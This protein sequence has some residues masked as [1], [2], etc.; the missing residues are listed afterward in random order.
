MLG[1]AVSASDY[2][3]PKR[4]SLKKHPVLNEKWIQ[5]LIAEDPSIL[6]LGDLVLL[7][8]ERQ[9]PSGGRLDL[10]LANTDD[11]E[12][13]DRYEVEV[14]LGATDPSHIIRTIEY[15]DTERTLRRGPNHVAVLVA[16]DI[17]SRFLNVISL[18]NKSVPIIA[19][20]MQAVEVGTHFTLVFTTVV[21]LSS[22]AH[23]DADESPASADR[24][25]W[26]KKTEAAL[27][28]VDE[29]FELVH[30]LDPGFALKYNLGFI[31]V[32]KGG[33]IFLSFTP[34]RSHTKIRIRMD[35]TTESED[36]KTQIENAGVEVQYL[37][38][39]KG[40]GIYQLSVDNEKFKD[41]SASV[42]ELVKLGREEIE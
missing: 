11:E 21:N 3:K 31:Q 10:L 1:V 33:R 8:K 13:G 16:E 29:L 14:Q 23:E 38:T 39:A 7:H 30:E 5:D 12:P 9:Q 22:R 6:G 15:W 40:S 41:Y 4:I 24:A 19:I 37:E 28:I 32:N 2:V 26:E 17:T 18:L 25:Y 20:Q 34:A 35:K 42:K 27:P 36:L